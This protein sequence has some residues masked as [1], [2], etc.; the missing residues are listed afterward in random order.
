MTSRTAR[1][2]VRR[3]HTGDLDAV[4]ALR[5]AL[6]E[7]SSNNP[8]YRRLRRDYAVAAR[9]IFAAQLADA[10]CLTLLAVADDE[11]IGLLR[12]TIS[13]PNALHEPARHAYVVS[14]YVRGCSRHSCAQRTRGVARTSWMRCD[15]TSASKTAP[16]T[17]RGKR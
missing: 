2:V 1:I 3:A 9:P 15:C 13:A 14:V 17:R 5:S 6:I 10:R 4:V 11:P 12:C 8:A 16:A 7:A